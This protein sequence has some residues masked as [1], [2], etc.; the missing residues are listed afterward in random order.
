MGSYDSLLIILF[1]II[2]QVKI[3]NYN[4][5]ELKK[6]LNETARKTKQF[7]ER[8]FDDKYAQNFKNFISDFNRNNF[9]SPGYKINVNKNQID[10]KEYSKKKVDEFY[11]LLSEF[12]RKHTQMNHLQLIDIENKEIP[13]FINE[14]Y[15]SRIREELFFYI[16]LLNEI[17][18]EQIR[19]LMKVVLS[20]TA[21]SCRATTHSD[22]ATL[23]KPIYDPYYCKKHYKICTPINTIKTRLNTYTKDT[24]KRIEEFS[25]LRKNVFA[26]VIHGDSKSIDVL[27]N[28]KNYNPEFY[29]IIQKRKI[30]GIFSSPPYVG[31]IDY[32][33][34]H[35]Y[36]YELFDIER[37]DDNEIGPMFK[38]K[39]KKAKEDYIE[40]ISLVLSNVK[41]FLK[42]DS[43]IFIVANDKFNLYPIIA[44]KSGL[45]IVNEYKRPVLNRTERDKQPYSEKIFHMKILHN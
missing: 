1:F 13:D 39:S 35:A 44:K 26:H 37:R 29:K 21:R 3:S 8:R 27:K 20:R 40:G 45:I 42:D 19:D 38:G 41:Q 16:N 43:N 32:H 4:I 25:K 14:W 7:S 28:I 15:T 18:D 36:A 9:P 6:I 33:E 23:V 12:K 34:Q 31:Q 2:S 24:I 10:E 5:V 11:E 17:E 30:D 22:L